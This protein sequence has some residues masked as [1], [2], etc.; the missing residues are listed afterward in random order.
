[1]LV[2]VENNVVVAYPYSI[3]QLRQDNPNVSFPRQPTPETFADFGVYSVVFPEPPAYDPLTQ[4]IDHSNEPVLVDGQWTI[5]ATVVALT[6]E[7]IE[8][9]RL[10]SVPQSVTPRQ[11]RLALLGAGL[12]AQVEA[13]IAA[14]PEPDKSVAVIEWEYAVSIER[15]SAWI[16]SLGTALGLDDL[17]LDQLFITAKTL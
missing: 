12:L 10:A 13:A 6:P 3:G 5:T 11:A 8:A 15:S 2:K 9:N 4:R 17:A 14:M 7:Q 1:M 16:G